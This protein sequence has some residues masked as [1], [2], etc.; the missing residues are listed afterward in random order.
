MWQCS[1]RSTLPR[2][3]LRRNHYSDQ[4]ISEYRLVPSNHNMAAAVNTNSTEQ[5]TMSFTMLL[6]M[7]IACLVIDLAVRRRR[8]HGGWVGKGAKR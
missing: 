2:E 1:P 8:R 3:W 5:V 7:C 4:I 6:V